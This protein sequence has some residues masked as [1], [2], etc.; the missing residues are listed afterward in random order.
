M[1]NS[2][3]QIMPIPLLQDIVND[4]CVPILGAGFSRNASLSK[5]TMPLWRDLG[6]FFAKEMDESSSLNPIDTISSYEHEFGKVK[7]VEKLN[8]FLFIDD[9]KPGTA[10]EAFCK[11][12]FQVAV[13]T[14]FDCLLE[15]TYDTLS[16]Y[17][18]TVIGEEELSVNPPSKAV[19]LLKL[20][21]DLHHPE[22]LIACEK[23]YDTF[24]EKYP[25]LATFLSNLLISNTPLFIGYSLEDPDFRHIWQIIDE[26]LGRLR[27]K[28]YA[29]CID[30]SKAE[31]RRFE[32]RNVRV[33]NIKRSGTFNETLTQ[34]FERLEQYWKQQTSNKLIP[35][36]EE[37]RKELYLPSESATRLCLFVVPSRLL[38]FYE[39]YVFPMAES[40]DFVPTTIQDIVSPGDN[41]IAKELALLDKAEVVVL[42]YSPETAE[43][44][45]LLKSIKKPEKN[46]LFMIEPGNEYLKEIMNFRSVTRHKDIFSGNEQMLEQLGDWFDEISKDLLPRLEEEPSRLLRIGEYRAAYISAM[47]LLESSI[48]DYFAKNETMPYVKRSNLRELLLKMADIVELPKAERDLF[49]EWISLRNYVLHENRQVA[50]KTARKAVEETLVFVKRIKESTKKTDA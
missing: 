46:L 41:I 6:D 36:K 10:H 18:H 13:T 8:D 4:H 35:T 26:R 33:I 44:V 34:L 1:K 45:G 30:Q 12:P 28:A 14:N 48:R 2:I 15:R 16:R 7:L 19:T 27:R 32:R 9:A 40:H 21:G 20:H 5:G 29:V 11:L 43:W 17:C 25:L 47:T 42:D 3:T 23:D 39:T 38:S 50:A 37:A 24:L 49:V 22:R 31:L